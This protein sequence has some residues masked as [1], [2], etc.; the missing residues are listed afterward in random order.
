MSESEAATSNPGSRIPEYSHVF[1]GPGGAFGY[2]ED[3]VAG[4][5]PRDSGLLRI[6]DVGCGN[7]YWALRLSDSGH[8]LVGID[9]S[10]QRI[11]KARSEVPSAR[12]EQ[13]DISEDL[14]AA[15]G[16]E[17]FDLVIST[18]VVEHLFL[19]DVWARACLA[20]LRPGGRF[21]CSTPYHGYL[22]NLLIALTN[23]WDRHHHTLRSVGHIKFFSEATLRQLLT[24][25][26]FGNIRFRGAGRVPL[27]W[28]SIVMAAERPR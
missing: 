17:P 13:L 11:A 28:K 26:G 4:F 18:E 1:A 15:L 8:R 10:A 25:A 21:V 14:L 24:R 23:S 7:G 9:A 6:L 12:F 5:L 20:A 3:A 19:P 27:L 22:K 16:E 2:L